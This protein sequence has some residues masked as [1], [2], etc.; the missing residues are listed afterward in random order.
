MGGTALISLVKFA[1][2][3][4]RLDQVLWT[5]LD[6]T[7]LSYPL[8]RILRGRLLAEVDR[9]SI[10][11]LLNAEE[12][13]SY[14]Q[15]FAGNYYDGNQE[16]VFNGK[17]FT[18]DNAFMFK[19][20]DKMDY[21]YRM[22]FFH[23]EWMFDSQSP[24]LGKFEKV[25]GK[26]EHSPLFFHPSPL[27]QRCFVLA[28]VLANVDEPG[29]YLG[30]IQK[31]LRHLIVKTEDSVCAN[32][33]I[34][35][36]LAIALLA[37]IL[38]LDEIVSWAMVWLRKSCT[39][40]VAA[41]YFCEKTPCYQALLLGRA[42]LVQE[43]LLATC[44]RADVA[45]LGQMVNVLQ[46]FPAV[47]MHDSYLPLAKWRASSSGPAPYARHLSLRAELNLT[48]ITDARPVRGCRGH[49]HDASGALFIH[50]SDGT[51]LIGG[52]GTGTYKTSLERDACRD[53][54]AYCIPIPQS[55]HTPRLIPWK[56]FRHTRYRPVRVHDLSSHGEIDVAFHDYR[57]SGACW[58]WQATS[59]EILVTCDRPSV[60]GF[61]SDLAPESFSQ[62]LRIRNDD[63]QFTCRLCTRFDGIGNAVPCHYYE[64]KFQTNLSLEIVS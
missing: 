42:R 30:L 17:R 56:S 57:G 64:V 1:A 54:T 18:V 20:I 44:G 2:L 41:G 32:H 51:Q 15:L 9:G 61:W 11:Y 35:N 58:R 10:C 12:F 4:L 39:E 5:I 34:D 52:R 37:K 43:A 47:H 33:R 7:R 49:A 21:T 23:F 16:W 38:G 40:W 63:A 22:V 27:S 19:S 50:Y 6:M 14:R 60:L 53:A 59:G 31:Y 25:H 48:L 45:F 28:W 46:R 8:K 26:L 3:S 36:F 24:D 13:E 55:G 29:A 62:F